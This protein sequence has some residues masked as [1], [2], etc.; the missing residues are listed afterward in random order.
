MQNNNLFAL[1]MMIEAV[2]ENQDCVL[3]AI[4][5]EDGIIAHLIPIEMFEGE[6]YDEDDSD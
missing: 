5:G 3:E 1:K 4:I 6:D 2:T